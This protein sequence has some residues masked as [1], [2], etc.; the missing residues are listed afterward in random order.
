M[1]I[2]FERHPKNSTANT[3]SIFGH[4]NKNLS[5]PKERNLTRYLP[6]DNAHQAMNL[7]PFQPNSNSTRH[8]A[9]DIQKRD[10]IMY[11]NLVRFR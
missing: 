1:K 6:S 9:I 5:A 4:L 10:G 7:K 11:A 2:K 8:A 3:T